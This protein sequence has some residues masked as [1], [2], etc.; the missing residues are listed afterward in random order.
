MQP[1]MRNIA[2]FLK[3]Q[4]TLA[5][6]TAGADGTPRSTPLFYVA[7]AGLELFW[8]S[9]ASSEHS[10][11]LERDS[12]AAVSVYRHAE[13]W[14]KIRGVQMRGV[15]SAVLDQER[16]DAI[17]AAYRKRFRLSRT[18]EPAIA[19]ST[20]YCFRPD[21]VRYLDNSKRFGYR[22]ESAIDGV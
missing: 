8:L 7:P 16:R 17:L 22:F 9:A 11:S 15:V 1:E 2:R 10:R 18:L 19:G 4:T 14:K 5:L 21:W 12:K 13:D 6:A 3:I 20:L